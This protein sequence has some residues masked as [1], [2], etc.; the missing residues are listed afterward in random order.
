[1]AVPLCGHCPVQLLLGKMLYF[2]F[3]CC[4]VFLQVTIYPDNLLVDF[5]EG[6]YLQ[7]IQPGFR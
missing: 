6:I 2:G 4:D 1:M 7:G 3:Y 5:T